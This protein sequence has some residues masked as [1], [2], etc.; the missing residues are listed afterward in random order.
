[1]LQGWQEDIMQATTPADLPQAAIDYVK[2][3]EE[4]LGVKVNRAS[5][6]P[7]RDQNVDF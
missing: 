2:Y 1:V 5:V 4:K 7:E 3:V 6:G